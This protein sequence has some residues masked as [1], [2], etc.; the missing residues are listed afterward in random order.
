M[1]ISG[2]IARRAG[3]AIFRRG[4]AGECVMET[5]PLSP[6]AAEGAA[7]ATAAGADAGAELELLFSMPGMSLARAWFKSGFPLPRHSHNVDCLYYITG[8]SLR[9]G[10][11]E[12]G[13]GDG[14]FVGADVPY[15]YTAGPEGVELL[16]F[17]AADVF[18]IRVLANNP[19]FW[20]KATQTA[21]E[22]HEGWARET[23]P[24]A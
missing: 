14:F 5:L 15:A 7:A 21:R 11:E 2:E 19:A 1:G 23:R 22:R 10:T 3:F 13:V 6:A 4:D 8:G 9:M 18:N 24:S 16:E 20:E 17:R 12:L